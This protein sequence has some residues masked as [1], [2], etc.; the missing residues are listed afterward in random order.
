[1][2]I[3]IIAAAFG[4]AATIGWAGGA[5]AH[6]TLEQAEARAG[7]YYKAVI[8]TPHGCSGS[9]TIAVKVRLPDGVMGAKPQPKPGWEVTTI[10]E[11]LTEPLK[12]GHGNAITERVSEVHWTGGRLLDEH[13]DEFA[14]RVQLPKEPGRTLYFPTVQEC[15]QGADRWI[16]IPAEGQSSD[17]LDYPAPKVKLTD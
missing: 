6:S 2:I 9:P 8:R 3:R 14:I 12:D 11:K 1:M 16:E 7:S 5:L 10:R 15:E 17:G 4:V 13:Y